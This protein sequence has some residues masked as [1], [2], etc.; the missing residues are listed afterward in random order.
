MS[1]DYRHVTYQRFGSDV[2]LQIVNT[3]TV[4]IRALIVA[5][6]ASLPQKQRTDCMKELAHYDDGIRQRKPVRLP[7]IAVRACEEQFGTGDALC[8]NHSAT[9]EME[10]E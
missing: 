8:P 10:R 3:Q 2:R 7:T 9:A 4:D 1:S 6:W 5:L